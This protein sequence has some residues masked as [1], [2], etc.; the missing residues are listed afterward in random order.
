MRCPKCNGRGQ[1]ARRKT[2]SCRGSEDCYVNGCNELVPCRKCEG[3]GHDGPELVREL[4]RYVSVG[5]A[6]IA[7]AR[8]LSR[9]C[10]EV[11]G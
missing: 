9:K 7:E 4:L 10:L 6:S 3:Y 11:M 1:H 5:C 2:C 8:R